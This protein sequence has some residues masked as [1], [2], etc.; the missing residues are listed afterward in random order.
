MGVAG[1]DE[2]AE[3]VDAVAEEEADVVDVVEEVAG[4]VD[5]AEEEE[6]VGDVDEEV[7]GVV[8]V[9]PQDEVPPML[10]GT[11]NRK[12]LRE[13][14]SLTAGISCTLLPSTLAYT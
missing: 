13:P 11:V 4:I 3:E 8:H 2:E 10:L 6:G 1:V 5:V 12:P 7:A 9:F 14:Y